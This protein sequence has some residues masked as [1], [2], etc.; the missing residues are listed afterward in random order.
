MRP[1]RPLL[2]LGLLALATAEPRAS[3]HDGPAYPIMV[4]RPTRYGRLSVWG[5]PDVGTGIFWII[6]ERSGA[7]PS[8]GAEVSLA[9]RPVD[10]RLEARSYPARPTQETPGDHR[11]RGEV[12]FDAR[13]MWWLR[14]DLSGSQGR[15]AVE[16]KVEVTPPGQGPVLDFVLHS[17][18]FVAVG[19]LFILAMVR[20]RRGYAAG[21]ETQERP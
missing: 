17:F 12:Q 13:G 6:L 8:G 15:E 5:D 20:R 16:E 14:V 9:V 3:A 11:F 2:L 1:R 10:G 4:D 19:G 21:P 7:A 18:P